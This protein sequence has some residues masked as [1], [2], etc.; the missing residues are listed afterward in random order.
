MVMSWF[1]KGV[2][3][4][5]LRKERQRIIEQ[6]PLEG[7]KCDCFWK[8]SE[9][10][11]AEPELGGLGPGLTG[12]H[13]L[14]SFVVARNDKR[15][16]LKKRFRQ[17]YTFDQM[18]MALLKEQGKSEDALAEF[19]V[20][21]VFGKMSPSLVKERQALIE[22]YLQQIARDEELVKEPLVRQFLGLPMTQEEADLLDAA[23]TKNNDGL[24]T[25]FGEHESLYMRM[26]REKKLGIHHSQR[27]EKVA[28]PPTL[29]GAAEVGAAFSESGVDDPKSGKKFVIR[30]PLLGQTV[31]EIFGDEVRGLH[32]TY[33]EQIKEQVKR[34]A[35]DKDGNEVKASGNGT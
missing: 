26:K 2:D 20:K 6:M 27:R 3:G 32:S 28:G 25:G 22:N 24:L 14:Y 31:K 34:S 7:E 33:G 21:K 4:E 9:E 13:T 18:L 8:D 29:G 16:V 23:A 10:I 35:K 1:S 19:P 12:E 11:R 5:A 17:L 30:I 15:W